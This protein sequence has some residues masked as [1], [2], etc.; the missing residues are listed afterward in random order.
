MGEFGRLGNDTGHES[1]S[2][3]GFFG[4]YFQRANEKERSQAPD[5]LKRIRLTP[6]RPARSWVHSSMKS[7]MM[8]TTGGVTV[9]WDLNHWIRAGSWCSRMAFNDRKGPG[10]D[11]GGISGIGTTKV[12]REEDECVEMSGWSRGSSFGVTNTV[13][14]TPRVSNRWV[15]SRNGI[16]WP[17]WGIV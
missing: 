15:R 6:T 4:R 11:E 7:D 17:E 2:S 3:F 10:G 13:T 9:A 8:A 14:I 1:S 16:R 12:L 5:V